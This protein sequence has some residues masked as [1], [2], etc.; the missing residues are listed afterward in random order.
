M[1]R[2]NTHPVSTAMKGRAKRGAAEAAA[3]A[4]RRAAPAPPEYAAVDLR[5]RLWALCSSAPAEAYGLPW[6]L[7][8]A[9]LSS[10][11]LL[12]LKGLGESPSGRGPR[13]AVVAAS[14]ASEYAEC[15]RVLARA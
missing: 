7:I 1:N 5:D 2:D 4:A 6:D 13:T 11:L 8:A 3:L 15:V 14:G 9:D 12:A 10:R